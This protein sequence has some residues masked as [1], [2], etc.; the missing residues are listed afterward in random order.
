MNVIYAIT[1]DLLDGNVPDL[2]ISSE[3]S[4][5]DSVSNTVRE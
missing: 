4:K 1:L 5:V 2:Q 3:A